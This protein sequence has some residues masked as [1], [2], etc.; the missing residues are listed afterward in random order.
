MTFRRLLLIAL[1]AAAL[2]PAGAS[3]ARE[4]AVFYYPW[5]G[6]HAQDGAYHHWAQNGRAAPFEIA[7]NFFPARGAYSSGDAAVIDAQMREIAAA[8]VRTVVSSWWGWG[9]LEDQRLPAVLRAANR[10]GVAVAAH[11]EPYAGR[12]L[13]TIEQD[14][15]HLR[16]LGIRDVYVY[17]PTDIPAEGWAALRPSLRDMRVFFRAFGIND[18]G[19]LWGAF[20]SADFTYHSFITGPDGV[21]RT[22]LGSLDGDDG[23][24]ARD[25]NNS[26]QVVGYDLVNG[27][28]HAFMT[29]PDGIGITDLG[30]LGGGESKA[31]GINDSGQVVGSSYVDNRHNNMHAFMTGPDGDGMTDLGTLGGRSSTAEAINDSGQVV[32]TSVMTDGTT[33]AFITGPDGADMKDLG[34]LGGFYSE[35]IDINDLGEV[36]GKAYTADNTNHSFL[37]SHGGITDL[38]LLDTVI[39]AGWKGLHLMDINNHGQMVGVGTN[40]NDIQEAF[41]LSY[42]SD[43]VFTPSPIFIPPVISPPP[44]PIPEPGTYAMLLAGLG[45]LGFVMWRRKRI[46]E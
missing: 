28:N 11:L 3:A 44:P 14:V 1:A 41:L 46:A 25:F 4:T 12:T 36:I 27:F 37:F 5:Y 42:T 6:T 38:N 31:Y 21:G 39:A 26:G 15:A 23:S 33:H 7:S 8:G 20:N 22:L 19:Q 18:S 40:R 2:A 16:T 29:G 32:G 35:A 43:T 9:S 34:T 13:A 30:T 10:R 45:L 17:R 24:V